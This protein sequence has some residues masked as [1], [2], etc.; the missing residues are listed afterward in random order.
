V[1]KGVFT[2]KPLS[3][4]DDL[5][6]ERYHFP[7]TY[8]NAVEKIV[9]DF[10]VYYEPRRIGVDDTV[11]GRQAYVATARV[12][13][14][15]PDPRRRD[16]YY[17]VIDPASYLDFATPVP[18]RFAGSYLERSLRKPDGTTNRGAFGRAVR[19][20]AEDEYELICR[21]GFAGQVPELPKIP[22]REEQLF[23]L[24][25]AA[26]PFERPIVETVVSRPL[27]DRAF[28]AR[29]LRAYGER[30]AVTGLLIRNGKQRPEAQAAHIRPVA[31]QGPDTVRNGLALSSTVHWM[32]DRGLFTL[33]DECRLV[34]ARHEIPRE[35][36][37]CLPEGRR[38]LLPDHPADRPD[39]RFL[40]F[41]REKVFLG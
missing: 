36:R 24:A 27:R 34:L 13:D 23:E 17:A 32:F 3:G 5:P 6:W 39:P 7:G 33:D 26:A 4:Y 1:A 14:L 11:G 12:V 18:F 16:H 19:L 28:Q 21:L 9:G 40:A 30:C 20:L 31:E 2:H 10:V 25:E 22:L 38:I 15:E 37:A 35:L 8:R 41:H 29:V